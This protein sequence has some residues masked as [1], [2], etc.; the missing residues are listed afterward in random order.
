MKP[1]VMFVM[2][3]APLLFSIRT[4]RAADTDAAAVTSASG[5]DQ[6]IAGKRF[7]LKDPEGQNGSLSSLSIDRKVSLGGG[8]GSAD[9][10]TLF[11]GSLRVR[12]ATGDRFDSTYNLP[13]AGWRRS[14]LPAETRVTASRARRGR[15]NGSS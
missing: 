11:G 4:A 10:P 3:V 13:T 9:D 12:T 8:N 15:S 5:A 7:M 14:A 1:V 6:P 2:M